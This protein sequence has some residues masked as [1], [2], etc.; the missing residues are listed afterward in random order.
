MVI[1][2]ISPF[3]YAIRHQYDLAYSIFKWVSNKKISKEALLDWIIK[4]WKNNKRI[5]LQIIK[6]PFIFYGISNKLDKFGDSDDYS[7][8]S[9][10]E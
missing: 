6:N 5:S 2:I 3:K 4:V 10:D 9:S 8:W 7:I 1:S